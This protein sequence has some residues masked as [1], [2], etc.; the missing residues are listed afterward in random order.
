MG[1]R[2]PAVPSST[3]HGIRATAAR[4]ETHPGRVIP[5]RALASGVRALVE[6]VLPTCCAGCGTGG[7]QWCP[8]CLADLTARRHPGG[9]QTRPEPCPAGLPPV[10]TAG[11]YAGALRAAVVG[12]KDGGR[13]DLLP[14]L[15]DLLAESIGPWT[16][17]EPLLLPMPS[18]PRAVRARGEA[19]TELLARRA[20]MRAGLASR[21]VVVSGLRHA[22]RVDD[23][24]RL[25]SAAR[26]ANLAGAFAVRAGDAAYL[27]GRPVLLVDDVVTTGATLA[28]GARAARA[29]GAHVLGAA[30][31]A[32]TSRRPRQDV[33]AR[34][35]SRV[36]WS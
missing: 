19:T 28:E 4:L 8:T 14:L 27:R 26:A 25:D 20:A 34:G 9:R 3:A 18:S 31:V 6:L 12:Y 10:R 21:T 35:G 13:S 15:A 1:E 32:A 16:S 33:A 11:E 22:R 24:A 5:L 30:V 2:T 36:T 17:D 7:E 23:Q 29:V